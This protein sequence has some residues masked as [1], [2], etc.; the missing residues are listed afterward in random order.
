MK[1]IGFPYLDHDLLDMCTLY[2]EMRICF[3]HY[4]QR[5]KMTYIS[6]IITTEFHH[7][8]IN[9][10]EIMFIYHLSSFKSS[11]ILYES[12]NDCLFLKGLCYSR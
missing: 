12:T 3:I 2:K 5:V 8:Y 7:T 11:L 10:L 1:A 4:L 6:H 9:N